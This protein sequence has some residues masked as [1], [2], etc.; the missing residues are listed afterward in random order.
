MAEST[1]KADKSTTPK[2]ATNAAA[3]RA[4]PP[5]VDDGKA[6]A[7][8]PQGGEQPTGADLDT[9]RTSGARTGGVT[10]A[11]AEEYA[12]AGVNPALD[13]RIGDQ[14]PQAGAFAAKPQQFPGPEV[15]H[16]AE[17]EEEVGP[18][19]RAEFETADDKA[20]GMHARGPHGRGE[21]RRVH[22]AG[23]DG[24]PAEPGGSGPV[25]HDD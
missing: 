16:F 3:P 7:T 14:R 15:G 25:A 12:A 8:E 19:F 20:M 9:A 5:K 2:T 18:A 24:N 11:M 6:Q 1:D 4:T 22:D 23:P 13:N 21:D 17:H 10:D